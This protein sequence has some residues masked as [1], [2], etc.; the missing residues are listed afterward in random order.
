MSFIP[1]VKPVA[2]IADAYQGGRV[3]RYLTMAAKCGPPY[4][5]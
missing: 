4:P 1:T 3:Y 2:L 5:A